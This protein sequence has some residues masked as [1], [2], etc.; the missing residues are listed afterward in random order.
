MINVVFKVNVA[1]PNRFSKDFNSQLGARK[2]LGERSSE[3]WHGLE[4]PNIL[5]VISSWDSVQAARSY[6]ASEEA[7]AH[8]SSWR[9]VEQPLLEYFQCR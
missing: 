2:A 1:Y 3:T 6:W 9:S 7:T 5:F 4:T 8:I